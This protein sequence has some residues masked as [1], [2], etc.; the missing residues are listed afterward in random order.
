[1]LQFVFGYVKRVVFLVI[2]HLRH[3]KLLALLLN[4]NVFW[5][6]IDDHH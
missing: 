4:Q 6:I 1:M 5:N 2:N 3:I